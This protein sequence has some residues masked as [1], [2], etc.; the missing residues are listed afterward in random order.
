MGL[1][2]ML[3]LNLQL[4]HQQIKINWIQFSRDKVSLPGLGSSAVLTA[5]SDETGACKLISLWN[6]PWNEF[7]RTPWQEAILV[8]RADQCL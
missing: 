8:P 4:C 3:T 5:P 7:P 6:T 1:Q 2:A